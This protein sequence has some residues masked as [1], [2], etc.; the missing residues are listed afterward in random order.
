MQTETTATD[1]EIYH[2]ARVLYMQDLQP[3]VQEL[4]IDQRMEGYQ[5][6]EKIE[7]DKGT[8]SLVKKLFEREGFNRNS[9][10][11]SLKTIGYIVPT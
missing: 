8:M 7:T 11:H 6:T 9:V 2:V 3:F 5:K 4:G 10:C 1:G